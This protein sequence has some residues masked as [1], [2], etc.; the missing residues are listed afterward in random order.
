MRHI[1][2]LLTGFFFC[3]IFLMACA[4]P[5]LQADTGTTEL[6]IQ[7]ARVSYNLYDVI[8]LILATF[9]GVATTILLTFLKAKYPKFFGTLKIP[10]DDNQNKT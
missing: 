1:W 5:T 3:L 9:G 2:N 7:A 10:A 6:P 4:S 8:R